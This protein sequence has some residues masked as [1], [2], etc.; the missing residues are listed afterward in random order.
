[1]RTL[2]PKDLR[3]RKDIFVKKMSRWK[4]QIHDSAF[5][6]IRNSGIH[7]KIKVKL[8]SENDLTSESNDS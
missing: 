1:M 6:I 4:L 7:K 5:E 3:S 8:E 2:L